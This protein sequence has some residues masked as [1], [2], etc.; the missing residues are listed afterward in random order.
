[1]R[2]A[3]ARGKIFD[4]YAYVVEVNRRFD[5]GQRL[6]QPSIVDAAFGDPAVDQ[7]SHG[8]SLIGALGM[9]SKKRPAPN[10]R[11]RRERLIQLHWQG[12]SQARTEF[13][14]FHGSAD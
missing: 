9:K 13:E 14:P 12:A 11:Q 1:M 4:P 10:A 2:H 6:S 8:R 3:A 5:I 7:K